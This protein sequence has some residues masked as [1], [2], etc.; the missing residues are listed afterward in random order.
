MAETTGFLI[1]GLV[2]VF[3]TLALHLLSFSVRARN[4]RADAQ[5]LEG[6][7]KRRGNNPTKKKAKKRR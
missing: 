4:L 6:L 2:V 7:G 1:L 5:M 3:G